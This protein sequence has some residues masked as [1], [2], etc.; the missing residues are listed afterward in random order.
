[1]IDDRAEKTAARRTAS[2]ERQIERSGAIMWANVL[3]HATE[4]AF[5]KSDT[6]TREDLIAA[7]EDWAR[8]RDA[9]AKAGS[10][11]AIARLRKAVAQDVR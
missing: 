8:D 6:V 1:M 10:N 3:A 7:L 4:A 11:E 9:L 2:Q 5:A